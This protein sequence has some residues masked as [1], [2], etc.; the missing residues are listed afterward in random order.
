MIMKIVLAWLLILTLLLPTATGQGPASI[1]ARI[2][3]EATMENRN[4]GGR[5]LPLA[6]HWN[7]GEVANGF[8]PSYQIKLIE[9]GHYLLPSFLMPKIHANPEDPHWIGYYQAPIRRAGELKLP[10]AL[11][12]T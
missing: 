2:R 10:I 3:E 9:Q 5:P 7:L 11:I 1:T 4:R 12:G 6:G 8:S